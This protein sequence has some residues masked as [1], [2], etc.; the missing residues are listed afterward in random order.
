[1]LIATGLLPW[2]LKTE[3]G[4]AMRAV[5][6]NQ[7]M[8]RARGISV[9]RHTILGPGLAGGLVAVGGAGLAA[10]IVGEPP[11][12]HRSRTRQ[13]LAPVVGAIVS[14]SSAFRGPG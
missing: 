4:I 14:H 9:R 1:M 5:G 12:G 3:V 6:A 10:V 2:F 11:V 7:V 8:T 13:L